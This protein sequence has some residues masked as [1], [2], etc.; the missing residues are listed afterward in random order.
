MTNGL[1]DTQ[2]ADPVYQRYRVRVRSFFTEIVS[3]P[4]REFEN[5]ASGL[6]EPPETDLASIYLSGIT[7]TSMLWLIWEDYCRGN[8]A[9]YIEAC[10]SIEAEL[11]GSMETRIGG[12]SSFFNTT[13]KS[14]IAKMYADLSPG[15][16][17][18]SWIVTY[19]SFAGDKLVLRLASLPLGEQL[20]RLPVFASALGVVDP[21]FRA[22]LD[23]YSTKGSDFAYVA[24]EYMY[25]EVIRPCTLLYT[26]VVDELGCSSCEDIAKNIYTVVLS[27]LE[28]DDTE[29][30]RIGIK[31]FLDRFLH[32]L[33]RHTL[34]KLREERLRALKV[35]Q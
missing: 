1:I 28:E 18:P 27:S 26:A 9:R 16:A 20:R 29:P 35:G 13:I 2:E 14:L 8:T 23:H 25:W 31:A 33:R 15:I 3:L 7:R 21:V 5:V 10:R 6:D 12:V 22:L 17:I 4:I 34:R 32:E 24:A 11:V 30:P 19:S